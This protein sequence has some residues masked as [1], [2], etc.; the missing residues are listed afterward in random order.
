MSPSLE[1]GGPRRGGDRHGPPVNVAIAF[2]KS[3]SCGE[4]VVSLVVRDYIVRKNLHHVCNPLESTMKRQDLLVLT[5]SFLVL[6]CGKTANVVELHDWNFG[7]TPRL[8][9][10]LRGRVQ[11][12]EARQPGIRVVQSDKSWHMIRE[13]LYTSFSTG[14]G[15]DVVNTHANYASEFGEAGHYYPINKFPDFEE[16]KKWYVPEFI[17]STR[18]KGSY[19]G[20]PSSA[21]AFALVCN[22]ELFRAEGLTPPKTWSQFREAAKRLTKDLD[23]DGTI[24]QYG[25][26]LLGGDKGGFAY[27]LIP[28]FYKAG[29]EVMSGDVSRITFNTP[30]G[31]ATL[32]L[33][34]DMFQVDH[35]ITPGFLAYGHTEPSD[36]FC[37][38]KVAMCIE[39]PWIRG[40]VNEKVPGKELTIVPIPVPDERMGDYDTAPTLQDMV[41]YSIN[42][43]SRNLDAAWELLKYLRNEEADMAWV[44]EDMGATAVTQAALNSKEAANVPDLPVFLKELKHAR[45][46]PMHP[47]I[48][49]LMSDTFTPFCERSIIGELTPR[50]GLDQAAREA[51]GVLNRG[52]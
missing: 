1:G 44:R 35:S 37:R 32:K 42:A 11:S 50:E 24:D 33:F 6:S 47:K 51:Q 10:W 12:F 7:G 15:P 26:V 21:I 18:Y 2:H 27:R 46:L 14:L 25:L 40:V 36:L 49:A 8:I 23:G 30:M 22:T 31:V 5:L 29:V 39:G 20:L 16:V 4:M 3:N 13:I 45:P 38:N 9:T 28:F 41:M 34:A 48:V 19:Y 43:H 52:E 17:E